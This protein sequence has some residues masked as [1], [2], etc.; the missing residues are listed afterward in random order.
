MGHQVADT[1]VDLAVTVVVM[2]DHLTVV[3]EGTMTKV[4]LKSILFD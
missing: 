3:V 1:V 4:C 2:V